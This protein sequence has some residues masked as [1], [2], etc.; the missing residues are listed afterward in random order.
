MRAANFHLNLLR[1]QERLLSS[2]I[3]VRVMLPV[4]ALLFCVAMG[5]W[6]AML[7]GQQ[8]VVKSQMKSIQDGL[9]ASRRQHDEI[10]ANMN[11]ARN[12]QA[13]L[14]QLSMY[15]HARHAYGET[16]A[17]L[18]D[19]LPEQV[20]LVSL[21]IPEPQPQNLLPPGAKPGG[22][23]VPLLGPTGTVE[24]VSLRLLG[25]APAVAPVTAF[26]T[27]LEAPVFTNTLRIAKATGAEA[28]PRI[29]SF[30]QD[31]TTASGPRLLAF[32]VEY[33]CRERRFEK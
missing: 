33:A 13:E 24:T 6:W 30:K 12:L 8:M 10:V 18:A 7:F 17:H 23:F 20:Q 3:R 26:M 16:L 15:A 9:D 1:D 22:R 14:D 5:V 19:V 29:H 2:P 32:D 31:A 28:S 4:L 21:E 11:A 27:S 25:R